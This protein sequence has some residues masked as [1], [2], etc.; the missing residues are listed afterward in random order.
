MITLG[1]VM[2][3]VTVGAIFWVYGQDLPDH[4]QLENYQPATISRIY[5]PEGQIIDEFA[6]ERRIYAPADE[7]PDLVKQ[8]FFWEVFCLKFSAV[9]A[10]V[11][12][13]DSFS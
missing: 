7:I 1:L 9:W 5:S 2:G 8:A 12:F 11:S 13:F 4:A 6:E 3:A 10:I